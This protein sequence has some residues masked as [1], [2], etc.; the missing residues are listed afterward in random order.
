AQRGVERILHELHAGFAADQH[1]RLGVAVDQVMRDDLAGGNG[2]A[3][4]IARD[5][6]E[7]DGAGKVD[8][9]GVELDQVCGGKL[10][11][12]EDAAAGDAGAVGVDVLVAHAAAEIDTGG[13]GVDLVRGGACDESEAAGCVVDA[14]GD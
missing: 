14:R 11:A 3:D 6:V 8:T 9:C 12:A 2:D 4:G 1:A 5:A 7:A 10:V 13:V